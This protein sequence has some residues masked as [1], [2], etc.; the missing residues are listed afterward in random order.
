MAKQFLD[1]TGLSV[2]WN[3]IKSS[4]LSSNGG[5][6]NVE[7]IFNYNYIY[8]STTVNNN[9][10]GQPFASINFIDEC[11][12]IGTTTYPNI[13][14]YNNKIRLTEYGSTLKT[15]YKTW[16]EILESD[17]AITTSELNKVLV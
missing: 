12:T 17:T 9:L 1:A 11:I 4:F 5:G 14:L 15:T 8:F 7:W 16:K 6:I 10:R 2:L 3:K 13:T